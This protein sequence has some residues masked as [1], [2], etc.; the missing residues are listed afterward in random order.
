MGEPQIHTESEEI[1]LYAYWLALKKRRKLIGAIVVV[2][3]SLAVIGSVALPKTY[4][5]T[6]SITQ[7]R[8]FWSADTGTFVDLAS[9]DD[10]VDLINKGV[11]NKKIIASLSLDEKK[12]ARKLNNG[13]QA[14]ASPGGKLIYLTFV[15][16]EPN[17]GKLILSEFI[18][19]LKDTYNSRAENFRAGITA[20]VQKEEQDVK[21]F[22]VESETVAVDMQD[23]ERQVEMVKK[24]TEIGIATKTQERDSSKEQVTY[25]QEGIAALRATKERLGRTLEMMEKNTHDLLDGKT[26]FVKTPEAGKEIAYLLFANNLQVNLA[27]VNS[28]YELLKACDSDINDY[29]QKISKLTAQIKTLD[30]DIK[31][32]NIDKE[33]SLKRLSQD[34]E[35]LVLTKNEGLPAKI[36]QAQSSISRLQLK[37]EMVEEITPVAVPDYLNLPAESK[38]KL[39]IAAATAL[40]MLGAIL[41]VF[42]LEWED[43]NRTRRKEA[44]R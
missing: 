24:T 32:L 35:K 39:Y 43:I 41:I 7:G 44:G 40:S 28:G 17:E 6:A 22:E 4:K 38:T 33:S 1:D 16:D 9:R 2:A 37:K 10:I 11:L 8:L 13:I 31:Q 36:K 20:D 5:V 15:T 3:V 42:F 14:T 18:R 29:Q 27:A 25:F 30:E 21:L 23:I 12:Y 19:I 34:K 26:E